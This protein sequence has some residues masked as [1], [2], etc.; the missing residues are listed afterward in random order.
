MDNEYLESATGWCGLCWGRNGRH[1]SARPC[2]WRMVTWEG[3]GQDIHVHACLPRVECHLHTHVFN[4][5]TLSWG[6][7]SIVGCYWRFPWFFYINWESFWKV[8]II[9]STE[10]MNTYFCVNACSQV[11]KRLIPKGNLI[12][13]LL[14]KILQSRWLGPGWV[15]CAYFPQHGENN[16]HKMK[17]LHELSPTPRCKGLKSNSKLRVRLLESHCEAQ[18]VFLMQLSVANDAKHWP[19]STSCVCLWAIRSENET[20]A[21]PKKYSSTLK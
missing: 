9:T 16:T 8:I 4:W 6:L 1:S 15:C 2:W 21:G 7:S 17:K 5:D 13:W 12:Q 19:K 18:F 3:T 10:A 20:F 14:E 11:P